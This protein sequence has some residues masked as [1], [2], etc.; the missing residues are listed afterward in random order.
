MLIY[1]DNAGVDRHG[2]P[3]DSWSAFHEG[4]S[5]GPARYQPFSKEFGFGPTWYKYSYP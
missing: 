3:Y 2:V 1:D 4:K 5:F